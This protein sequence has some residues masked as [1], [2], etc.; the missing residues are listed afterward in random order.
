M[1]KTMKYLLFIFLLVGCTKVPE[2]EFKFR[3]GDKVSV[4]YGFYKHCI[5]RVEAAFH[6]ILLDN[7]NYYLIYLTC[8]STDGD[9][10]KDFIKTFPED[11]LIEFL[12]M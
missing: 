8:K 4:E 6:G 12:D 7:I 5:G 2:T 1:E 9:Y 3:F 11:Q 10:Q